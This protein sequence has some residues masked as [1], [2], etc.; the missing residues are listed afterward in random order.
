MGALFVVFCCIKSACCIKLFV[1]LIPYYLQIQ[2][3]F[4]IKFHKT[5][6]SPFLLQS[7]HYEFHTKE[8][9][10]AVWNIWHALVCS[11][12][13]TSLIESKNDL[14]K[15]ALRIIYL[16]S[17]Y[18]KNKPLQSSLH[19]LLSLSEKCS[20]SELFWLPFSCIRTEYGE[21]PPYLVRMREN[22]DQN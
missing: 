18:N 15:G 22:A 13:S 21:I 9:K 3:L 14:K 19:F 12:Y 1:V 20:Y 16:F 11:K 17:K 8:L 2:E 7:Y 5:L 6:F 4:Y 10:H